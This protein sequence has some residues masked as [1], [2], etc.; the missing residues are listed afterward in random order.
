MRLVVSRVPF[1]AAHVSWAAM[2]TM[3]LNPAKLEGSGFV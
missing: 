1:K 3:G 2:A